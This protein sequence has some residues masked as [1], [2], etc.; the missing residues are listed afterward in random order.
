MRAA[1]AQW[2]LAS[3]RDQQKRTQVGP[4]PGTLHTVHLIVWTAFMKQLL[5]LTLQAPNAWRVSKSCTPVRFAFF[6][7]FFVSHTPIRTTSLILDGVDKSWWKY[8]SQ[9]TPD[10]FPSGKASTHESSLHNQLLCS[11]KSIQKKC[12]YWY[13]LKMPL[14]A[15][16]IVF[17]GSL[18]LSVYYL[19]DIL[20]KRIKS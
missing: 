7:D 16:V 17:V 1:Q 8:S 12:H 18:P 15:L 10:V 14:L 11:R 20:N 5:L 19:D 3:A 2:K 6:V 13:H 4:P 9:I